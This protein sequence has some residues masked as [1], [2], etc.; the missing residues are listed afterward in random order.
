M[1]KISLLIILFLFLP[2]VYAGLESSNVAIS[3]NRKTSI[4][5]L[6]PSYDVSDYY[7]V[8]GYQ[9]TWSVNVDVDKQTYSDN[10]FINYAYLEE[11][12]WYKP[13][14]TNS[15]KRGK[16]PILI[17]SC[18]VVSDKPDEPLVPV[19]WTPIENIDFIEEDLP[20]SSLEMWIDIY[21]TFKNFKSYNDAGGLNGC[22]DGGY[23]T[24]CYLYL[25]DNYI[26]N[27]SVIDYYDWDNNNPPNIKDVADIDIFDNCDSTSEGTFC[28]VSLHY[29]WIINT[30][31]VS[32]ECIDNYP[33]DDQS[34]P[35][36]NCSGDLLEQ[37]EDEDANLNMSEVELNNEPSNSNEADDV[38]GGGGLEGEGSAGYQYAKVKG[39]VI[40]TE[41]ARQQVD[42]LNTILNIMKLLFSFLLLIFYLIEFTIIIYIPYEL[43]PNMYNK[44][45]EM[46]EK[47]G[48]IK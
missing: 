9:L 42:Y 47:A 34:F 23:T 26:E 30:D 35:Y 18:L 25:D 44:L 40:E 29:P 21:R 39:Y 3:V 43:V 32:T 1:K 37:I 36:W 15:Y 27:P 11:Y 38:G 5:W 4:S 19:I 2:V 28:M 41:I 16:S 7:G 8:S 6:I 12:E 45:I 48:K 31:I 22:W 20:Y 46:I 10:S 13:P 14:F 24:Y 33:I 17:S